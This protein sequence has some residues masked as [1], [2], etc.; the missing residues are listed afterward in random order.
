MDNT[1]SDTPERRVDSASVEGQLYSEEALM[2][3]ISERL[4]IVVKTIAKRAGVN[5]PRVDHLYSAIEKTGPRY[6]MG[7]NIFGSIGAPLSGFKEA[8]EMIVKY[9]LAHDCANYALDR[10]HLGIK[11]EN[12][13]A[14]VNVFFDGYIKERYPD[15][16]T[17]FAQLKEEFLVQPRLDLSDEGHS[18]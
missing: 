3:H 9:A 8:N 11:G 7:L 15:L 10:E 13:E 16:Y 18:R 6:R 1:N 2:E 12:L 17:N 4:D 14:V 5:Q